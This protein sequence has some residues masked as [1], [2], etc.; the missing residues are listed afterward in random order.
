MATKTKK[1][2]LIDDSAMGVYQIASY[3]DRKLKA[4]YY[5]LQETWGKTLQAQFQTNWNKARWN[6]FKTKFAT[7]FGTIENPKYTVEQMIEYS[8]KHFNKGLEELLEVNKRTW[9]Q[10]ERWKQQETTNF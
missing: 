8:I 5:G 9:Q 4:V 3:N 6:D 1:L 7:T 10:R 2:S